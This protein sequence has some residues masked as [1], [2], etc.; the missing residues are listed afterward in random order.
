MSSGL[1]R[2][3]ASA[4]T[5]RPL[6]TTGI[7]TFD[8]A[9][10]TPGTTCKASSRQMEIAASIDQRPGA[11]LNNDIAV[12]NHAKARIAGTERGWL[13]VSISDAGCML[14]E[15]E[16]SGYDDRDGR[17]L[18]DR[19]CLTREALHAWT[20]APPRASGDGFTKIRLSHLRIRQQLA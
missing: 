18:Q 4:A 5:S 8:K 6:A 2:S 3:T 13:R 10:P 11:R 20:N 9:T 19:A 1:P 16:E 7:S 15:G 12:E 14:E 17:G